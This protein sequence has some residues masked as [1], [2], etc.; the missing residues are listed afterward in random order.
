MAKKLQ[1]VLV[2]G[3]LMNGIHC[4]AATNEFAASGLLL[5][6]GGSN[7]YATLVSPFSPNVTTPILTPNWEAKG[8]EADFSGGFSINLKHNF[9]SGRD[10]QLHW[11][12]LHT[13]DDA[14]FGVNRNP[15]PAQQFAGPF[16]NVGPDAGTTSTANGSL[17]N[18]YDV[19]N[20]E[21]GK[22]VS[23]A[24]DLNMRFFGGLSALWIHQTLR[25]NFS[26]IDPILGLYNFGIATHSKYHAGGMRLG[27]ESEYHALHCLSIVG[28]L[29]GNL[30][31][32]SQQP[33]TEAEGSGSI[34]AA[35]GIGI[36]HQSISHQSYIQ[37][38]PGLDAKLGLKYSHEYCPNKFFTLEAG[39]MASMYMNT[40]QNYVPST[41]VPAS[42][43]IVA[44]SVYLQSLIKTTESFSLDG[45]YLTV[46]LKM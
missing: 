20:A 17:K 22:Q 36:N 2:F 23:L 42:L 46:A 12:H 43:G 32:G 19:V 45:P 26:G 37:M 34:L 41:Y 28:K 25:A 40:I 27:L 5:R 21:V 14:T 35:G 11:A 6:P 16:W 3:L 8:M 10:V 4:Q 29:A 24:P 30:F 18:S 13:R 39:Y 9:H 1:Q 31:I 38:A 33:L 7:D 44:G 15:P